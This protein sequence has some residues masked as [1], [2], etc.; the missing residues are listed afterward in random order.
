MVDLILFPSS[1][2]S[3]KKVDEDLQEEY[4][5]VKET[6]LFDVV[7]FGYDS[8]FREGR[9]VLNEAPSEMRRALMRGWMMKPQQYEAFYE[10]LL[11]QNIQLITTPKE[12][13]LMHIFPNV[14]SYFGEDTARMSIY[15][16]HEQIDIAEVKKNYSR[17]M[18][19][20]FVKSVKGTEFPGFFDTSVTQ[21]DFDA[22][23]EVFYRYRGELLTGGICV[24]EFLDLKLYEGKPNEYR[25]FYVNH[26]VLSVSR[27]IGQSLLTPQP[28]KELAEKYKGLPSVY[29]TVDYAEL[30]DG[31]W[32]VLEA[33][34]GSVSGLSLKQDATSYFRGL[35]YALSQQQEE[36]NF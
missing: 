6:G 29:Y 22:L 19:K 13:E 21:E 2:L 32:K 4:E 9:L 31:T 20:D 35:Y 17:F 10:A 7:F 30:S 23:M 14:H 11:Q 3:V 15:P 28:P 26:Q 36:G 18:I 25:V 16:L 33:G 5:A 24:K 1:F 12:Y 27:N 34:D 8:W